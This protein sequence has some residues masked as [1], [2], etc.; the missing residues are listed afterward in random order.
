MMPVA[1]FSEADWRR[2]Q[3]GYYR[4][5]EMVDRR[6]GEIMESLR[7]AGLEDNTLVVFVS[8]H[9]DGQ[10]AHKWNQKTVFYDESCRVP[11]AFYRPGKIEP[12]SRDQPVQTGIDLMPTL[13]GMAGIPP[14][15]NSLPGNDLSG[16][17]TR[18]ETGERDYIVAGTHFIQG[19]PIDGV[20]HTPNGRM[21]RSR[22][23][24]YC[25]YDVGEDSEELYDMLNDP[26][27]MS[28]L[29]ANPD[30]RGILHE[31]REYLIE[32]CRAHQDEF[33][34]PKKKKELEDERQ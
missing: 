31:H 2:L 5:I 30:C 19:E 28:N 20:K 22:Q 13:C 10:G 7:A 23:Y 6:L 24:K 17:I 32:Y 18:N 12:G 3:F 15:D 26:W 27:E 1:D 29:A 16:I 14:P 11:F 21:V 9:G 4:M 8:D 33:N 25:V 34:P